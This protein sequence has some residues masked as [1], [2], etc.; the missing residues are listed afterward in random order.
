MGR[1]FELKYKAS[2]AV[3]EQIRQTVGGSFAAIA[4]ETAYFDT[5]AGDLSARKWTL[6]RRLE[7]GVSICTVKTPAVGYGRG[8]W[9][10]PCEEITAAVPELCKLGAPEE[11]ISL[12]RGGLRETCGVRFTRLAQLLSGNGA[13]MELALDQGVFLG[14]GREK[15]FCIAELE[16][17]SGDEDAALAF[18]AEFAAKFGLEPEEK[19]KFRQAM[20]LA[21][22]AENGTI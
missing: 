12:C 11:L 21:R 9:E 5:P 20:E 22:G 16:L 6:R 17:K 13:A 19:S 1:E 15:P 10:V 4:M 7:N 18:A 14:G 8:E 3:L 2:P